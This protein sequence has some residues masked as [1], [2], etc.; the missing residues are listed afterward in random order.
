MTCSW[1]KPAE[2]LHHGFSQDIRFQVS[3]RRKCEALRRSFTRCWFESKQQLPCIPMLFF[4]LWLTACDCLLWAYTR[5]HHFWTYHIF[6]FLKFSICI[7][8]PHFHPFFRALLEVIMGSDVALSIY[9]GSPE[10]SRDWERPG[11]W[12]P[13]SSM[14]LLLSRLWPSRGPWEAERMERSERSDNS[15]RKI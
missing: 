5:G 7:Y 6:V 13:R 14:A 9:A 10:I 1:I 8:L 15:D 12:L 3:C 4:P 11:Q 2:E